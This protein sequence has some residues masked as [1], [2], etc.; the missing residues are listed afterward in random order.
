MISTFAEYLGRDCFTSL[1]RGGAKSSHQQEA[2]FG[3]V[4]DSEWRLAR[5]WCAGTQ[6]TN[7]QLTTLPIK[8][9]YF[10]CFVCLTIGR[11]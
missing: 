11:I 3:D 10:N 7:K 1:E 8:I 9:K 4:L 6:L 2:P 5:G